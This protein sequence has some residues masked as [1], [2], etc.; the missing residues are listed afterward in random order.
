MQISYSTVGFKDRSLEDA[1]QGIAEAGYTHVELSSMEP[2]LDKIPT[3]A[4]LER[5][6]R[7]LRDCGLQAG[8]LHAPLERNVLGAPEEDWRREKVGLCSDYLRLSSE[9][10]AQGMVIHPVPNPMFVENP[11][12]PGRPQAIADAVRRSLNDLVPVAVDSGVRILLENLPYKCDYPLLTMA[13]L[14]PLVDGYPEESVGLVIDTGHAWTIGN[15]PVGEIEA[16]GERLW[17]THL[18]D[19]DGEDPQDNHWAPTH[20][21][22]DWRAIRRALLDVSYGGHWTFEVIR[23]RDDHDESMEELAQITYAAAGDL[24]LHA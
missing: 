19:V 23:P 18:Q 11:E 13:E 4:A 8:T 6:K 12:H 20:G 15:D 5:V 2:H 17:G 9:L 22:L 21:E 3:G 1:L 14:R 16:A 10:G 7:C 24:N